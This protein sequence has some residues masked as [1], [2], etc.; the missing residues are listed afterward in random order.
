[1]VL[2]AILLIGCASIPTPDPSIVWS[3]DFEDGDLEGWEENNYLSVNEGVLKAGPFGGNIQHKSDVSY[4]TWSFDVLISENIGSQNIIGVSND[5]G[6]LYSIGIEIISMKYPE[7][8]IYQIDNDDAVKVVI[9]HPENEIYGWNHFD[10]TRDEEG[11]SKVYLNGE[12]ILEYKD[13][14]PITSH[15][16]FF[17]APTGSALDNIVVLNRVIDIQ[18]SEKE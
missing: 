2:L 6:Y 4:G 5:E 14:L 13:E 8:S 17:E 16:F 9:F 1:M 15:W 3:D 10:I 18:P 7:I 11:N 12:P